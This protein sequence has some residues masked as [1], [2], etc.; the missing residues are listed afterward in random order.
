MCIHSPL[1]K[2]YLFSLATNQPLVNLTF[3]KLEVYRQG[4]MH[5]LIY[6]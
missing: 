1:L 2:T 6:I 5:Y 3:L 4:K